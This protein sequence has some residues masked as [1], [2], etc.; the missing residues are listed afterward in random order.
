MPIEQEPWEPTRYPLQSLAREVAQWGGYKSDGRPNIKLDFFP[1]QTYADFDPASLDAFAGIEGLAAGGSP[2]RAAGS[3]LSDVLAGGYLPGSES[4]NPYVD[5][6]RAALVEP[7]MERFN[8]VMMPGLQNKWFGAHGSASPGM[9]QEVGR[10]ARTALD[11]VN[12]REGALLGDLWNT[13]RSRQMAAAGMAPSVERGMYTPFELLRGVGAEREAQAQR[14]IDEDIARYESGLTEPIRRAQMALPILAGLGGQFPET[15]SKDMGAGGNLA[16]TIAGAGLS[17]GGAALGGG[18]LNN[19]FGSQGTAGTGGQ[20]I[21]GAG[22]TASN[23]W[24][25]YGAFAGMPSFF[26]A[27]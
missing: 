14:G 20:S 23:P 1:G 15:Q 22:S 9:V 12:R 24:S 11:E 26:G 8:E 7:M 16:G 2:S 27:I 4:A 3:Y 19:I 10:E 25:G 13:E 6:M 21:F 17:L 5:D 18:M